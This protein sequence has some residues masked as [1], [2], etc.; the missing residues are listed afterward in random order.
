MLGPAE[1]REGA[2]G[3][4]RGGGKGGGQELRPQQCGLLVEIV[5]LAGLCDVYVLYAALGFL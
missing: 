5:S 4:T 3:G 2:A 1:G